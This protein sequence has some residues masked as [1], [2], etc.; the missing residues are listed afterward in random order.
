MADRKLQKLKDDYPDI[1]ARIG[2]ELEFGEMITG[3]KEKLDRGETITSLPFAPSR[4]MEVGRIDEFLHDFIKTFYPAFQ[5][6]SREATKFR[7]KYE[8][9]NIM[10]EP[11]K[12]TPRPVLE[13][14]GN[15]HRFQEMLQAYVERIPLARAVEE[16]NEIQKV[17]DFVVVDPEFKK[18]TQPLEYGFAD[19]YHFLGMNIP[20]RQ[21]IDNGKKGEA[22]KGFL[23]IDGSLFYSPITYPIPDIVGNAHLAGVLQTDISTSPF[24]ELINRYDPDTKVEGISRIKKRTQKGGIFPAVIGHDEIAMLEGVKQVWDKSKDISYMSQFVKGQERPM[25][26]YIRKNLDG[27]LASMQHHH[28]FIDD[29][30]KKLAKKE[31]VSQPSKAI[32]EVSE[33]RALGLEQERP[34]TFPT[35]LRQYPKFQ[36]PET[37]GMS[38]PIHEYSKMQQ[39]QQLQQYSG[40]VPRGKMQPGM[41]P[42]GYPKTR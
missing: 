26:K 12:Y 17:H 8:D 7:E 9:Y 30:R 31:G 39:L 32:T 19:L 34:E 24:L 35:S 41:V 25:R 3:L 5:R 4:F 15:R 13:S 22:T 29:Q 1:L 20:H 28:A 21:I 6:E 11:V 14:A 42:R 40:M 38:D 23:K 27:M 18:I 2:D 36:H 33:T 10:G 37:L 16:L